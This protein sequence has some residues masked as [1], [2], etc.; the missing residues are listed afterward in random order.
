MRLVVSLGVLL[1]ALSAFAES[2]PSTGRVRF[3][4]YRPGPAPRLLARSYPETD[5]RT[6]RQRAQPRAQSAPSD[7][8]LGFQLGALA[9]QNNTKGSL[10]LDLLPGIRGIYRQSL[11]PDFVFQASLGFF[12]QGAAVAQVGLNENIFELGG[13][14]HYRL[15]GTAGTSQFLFGLN[16]RVDAVL[17]KIDVLGTTESN[18]NFRFRAGPALGAAILLGES[19]SAPEL[20]IE[21][22]GTLPTTKPMRFLFGASLGLAFKL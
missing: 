12:K 5:F 3:S 7:A 21:A 22:E 6:M 10:G 11:S 2:R 13:G 14:V 16:A 19:T 1:L 4:P 15:S 18:L 20:L 8:A 17:S 9:R